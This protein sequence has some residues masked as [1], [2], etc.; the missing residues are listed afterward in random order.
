VCPHHKSSLCEVLQRAYDRQLEALGVAA[1]QLAE[2]PI[3]Q[4]TPTEEWAKENP[5]VRDTVELASWVYPEQ[6]LLEERRTRAELMI[7]ICNAAN[8]PFEITDLLRNAILK[9]R[10]GAPI[11]P[12]V[13][14]TAVLALEEKR[15]NVEFSWMRFALQHCQCLKRQHDSDCKEAIRKAA[16]DLQALMRRLDIRY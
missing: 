10:K 6:Y 5:V 1:V 15:S 14:R 11:Q 4:R 2:T 9:P 3:E 12:A 8:L 16:R 7:A 13:R